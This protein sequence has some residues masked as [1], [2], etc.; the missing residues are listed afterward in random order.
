[1]DVDSSRE[2]EEQRFGDGA[3][4]VDVSDT[5]IAARQIWKTLHPMLSSV[6]PIKKPGTLDSV[7]TGTNS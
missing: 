7:A 4:R 2:P 6:E 5:P 3:V 1:M